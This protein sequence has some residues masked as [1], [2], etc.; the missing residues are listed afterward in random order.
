MNFIN[1][2]YIKNGNIIENEWNYGEIKMK[3]SAKY[4]DKR[5][6]E[7]SNYFNYTYFKN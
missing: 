2:F 1:T 7:Y 6:L 3:E 4:F 5:K